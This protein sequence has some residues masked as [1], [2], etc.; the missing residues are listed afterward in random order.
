MKLITALVLLSAAGLGT[1]GY[2]Q[3]SPPAIAPAAVRSFPASAGQPK[4]APEISAPAIQFPPRLR[5]LGAPG[6]IYL[7]QGSNSPLGTVTL[8]PNASIGGSGVKGYTGTGAGYAWVF[9]QWTIPGLPVGSGMVFLEQRTTL[10]GFVAG[11]GSPNIV[12]RLTFIASMD[13]V[14]PGLDANGIPLPPVPVV[15]Y[16]SAPGRLLASDMT[17]NLQFGGL[18]YISPTP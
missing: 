12:H 1:Y 10:T 3:N 2:Y 18:T 7:F 15:P 14:S 6:D 9:Y 4:S 16:F 5:T 13:P 17:G 8:S 11:T